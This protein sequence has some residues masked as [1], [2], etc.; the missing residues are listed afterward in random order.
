[1]AEAPLAEGGDARQQWVEACRYQVRRTMVSVRVSSDAGT[2]EQMMVAAACRRLGARLWELT[3]PTAA[4]AP[5]E[6]E[7]EDSLPAAGMST[8]G[9]EEPP[10]SR[11]RL[12]SPGRRV[13][14]ERA[15][16]DPVS[17]A[18]DDRRHYLLA[19]AE[20]IGAEAMAAVINHRPLLPAPM[21]TMVAERRGRGLACLVWEFP[22]ERE[23][24][25]F[26]AGAEVAPVAAGRRRTPTPRFQ[27]LDG[28][29]H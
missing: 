7:A 10:T 28:H 1:M 27:G 25:A 11:P 2:E 9:R 19:E 17:V 6:P 3:A 8:R 21:Y 22:T 26:R 14:R 5:S 12:R 29:V 13:P 20:E 23:A 16:P 24:E 4:A 15:H 18:G